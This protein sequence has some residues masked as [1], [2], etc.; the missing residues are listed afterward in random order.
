MNALPVYR[1]PKSSRRLAANV[2]VRREVN[3]RSSRLP[4]GCDRRADGHKRRRG[5]GGSWRVEERLRRE[6]VLVLYDLCRR[7][8]VGRR[9]GDVGDSLTPWVA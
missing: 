2:L 6:R 4:T 9:M 1:P 5:I 3:E 8:R 7:A